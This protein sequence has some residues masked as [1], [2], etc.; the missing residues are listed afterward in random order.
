MHYAY[1]LAIAVAIPLAGCQGQGDPG[2]SE[3]P[4]AAA[5]EDGLGP[6]SESADAPEPGPDD[7]LDAESGAKLRQLFE[8]EQALSELLPNPFVLNPPDV[9]LEREALPRTGA[10]TNCD[11]YL[12]RNADEA[13]C[14]D[15]PPEDWTPFE[16]DGERYFIVPL[17]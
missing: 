17:G 15:A 3:P 16:F 2:T 5:A 1:I 12:T 13:F 8:N 11:G 6:Q 7:S 9:R 10:W 4:E 14:E